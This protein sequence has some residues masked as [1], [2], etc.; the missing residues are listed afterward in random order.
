MSS[1]D[2]RA[3]LTDDAGDQGASREAFRLLA[4]IVNGRLARRLTTVIDATN[5]RAVDRRRYQQQA[6]RNGLPTVAIA[7]D[8]PLATYHARNAGTTR[9]IR[10]RRGRRRSSHAH[11][12]RARELR[13]EGYTAV[14]V[15]AE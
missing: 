2:L 14:H 6:A 7:F 5:L 9:S 8:L 3:L 13:D 12:A 4:I 11:G 1:D 15:I 10:Q